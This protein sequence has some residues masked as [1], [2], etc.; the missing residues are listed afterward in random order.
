MGR[1]RSGDILNKIE[2]KKIAEHNSRL[3]V[4]EKD[5]E[6]KREAELRLVLSQMEEVS[7]SDF[8]K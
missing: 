8:L 2:N 5:L 3:K 1:V 7:L 4:I 6:E